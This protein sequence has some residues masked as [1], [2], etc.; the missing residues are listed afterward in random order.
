MKPILCVPATALVA[1]QEV[2]GTA[3]LPIVPAIFSE[4]PRHRVPCC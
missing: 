2:V 3:V 1:A 4:I